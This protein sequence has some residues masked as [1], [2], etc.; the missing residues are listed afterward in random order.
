MRDWPTLHSVKYL[1]G[2][3]GL[4]GYYRRFFRNYR[5]IIAYLTALLKKNSFGWSA[6]AQTTDQL[7]E[8]M[9]TIPVLALPNFSKQFIIDT[10]ASRVGLGG[11]LM[12]EGILLLFS[13][14]IC[15]LE[16]K[17]NLFM[18]GNSWP[19]F[20]P[21]TNGDTIYWVENS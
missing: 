18:R 8:A 19:L 12:Q 7:K 6:E 9:A 11:V 21:P 20:L 13:V 4:T 14:N 2:F 17:Q 15:W 10:N 1:R 16:L 3:L 5:K